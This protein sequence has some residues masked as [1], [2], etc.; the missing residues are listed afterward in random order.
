MLLFRWRTR[1]VLWRVRRIRGRHWDTLVRAALNWGS[2]RGSRDIDDARGW[3][4]LRQRLRVEGCSHRVSFMRLPKVNGMIYYRKNAIKIFIFI[5]RCLLIACMAAFLALLIWTGVRVRR[6]RRRRPL[7][8]VAASAGSSRESSDLIEIWKTLWKSS[9]RTL[10]RCDLF[11]FNFMF[12]L[13]ACYIVFYFIVCHISCFSDLVAWTMI[14]GE[15][16]RLLLLLLRIYDR[17][18]L[19]IFVV[20]TVVALL[21]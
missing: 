14:L 13:I 8:V 5:Y 3:W 1:R 4:R 12:C 9:E 17:N 16:V 15:I 2:R 10:T 21:V 19:D 11:L 6:C 20:Y 18:G 7:P